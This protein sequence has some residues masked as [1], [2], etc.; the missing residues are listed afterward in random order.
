LYP[1]TEARR[2]RKHK[3]RYKEEKPGRS[4]LG[5]S[6]LQILFPLGP[7]LIMPYFLGVLI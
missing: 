1:V 2:K 7:G 4:V 6:C 3:K 5:K